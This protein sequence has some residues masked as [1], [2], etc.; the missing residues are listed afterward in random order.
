MIEFEIGAIREANKLL[1]T[2][3]DFDR[4]YTFYYDETNNIKKFYV[5]ENDFNTPYKANFVLGGVMHEGAPPNLKP[6]FD[7]LKLQKSSKELKFKHLAKGEFLDCLKSEKLAV[8]LSFLKE[9][10]LYV[11]FSSLNILYWSIVDIIDSAIA[12]SEV[13]KKL[14]PQF[15]NHLKND[16]YMIAKLELEDFI[17]LFHAYKYPNIEDGQVVS[18]IRSIIS[19]FSKYLEDPEYHFGLESLQQILKESEKKGTLPFIQ[20]AED[21]VLIENLAHFYMRPIYLFKNS[22]HIIDNE[23]SITEMLTNHK[24]LE[25]GTEIKNYSFVDSQN[26]QFIQ[27]SD[28]IVGLIGKLTHYFNTSDRGKISV[29]FSLI[30]ETQGKNIDL[31]IDLFDKSYNKN[32]AFL[33]AI[34]SFEEVTKINIIREIRNKI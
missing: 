19:I 1:A 15:S 25:N 31:L 6:L 3:G 13:S 23:A 34:D 30:S 2:T 8:F 4:A 11:H 20:S 27:C 22:N 24:I 5:K 32:V 10:D 9:S 14:G 26:N 17:E 16:L 18:F 21:F 29:E 12:N 28:G 33:H 7:A